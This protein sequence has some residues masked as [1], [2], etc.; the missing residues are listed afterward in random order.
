MTKND[1]AG[2]GHFYVERVTSTEF[3]RAAVPTHQ[4]CDCASEGQY[5]ANQVTSTE[6]GSVAVQTH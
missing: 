3:G 2:E 6:F 5:Y 4:S 1:C